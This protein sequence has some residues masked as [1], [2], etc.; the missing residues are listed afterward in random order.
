MKLGE[1]LTAIL[2]PRALERTRFLDPTEYELIQNCKA[3][4][5][6]REAERNIKH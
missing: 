5:K 1:A 6:H 2:P 4:R 3:R